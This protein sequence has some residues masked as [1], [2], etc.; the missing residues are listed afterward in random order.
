[1]KGF[2]PLHDMEFLQGFPYFCQGSVYD[3]PLN[4]LKKWLRTIRRKTSILVQ[5]QVTCIFTNHMPFQLLISDAQA[6][7]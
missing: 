3:N 7:N 6:D 5:Q 4:F 1:M 2:F